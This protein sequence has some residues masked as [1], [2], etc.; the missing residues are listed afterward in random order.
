MGTEMKIIYDDN[1][2]LKG[3]FTAAEGGEATF[4]KVKCNG[5]PFFCWANITPGFI[6]C[7]FSNAPIGTSSVATNT[8]LIAG[9]TLQPEDVLTYP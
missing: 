3:P 4:V 8:T 6:A 7:D 1:G 2:T 5:K 9:I